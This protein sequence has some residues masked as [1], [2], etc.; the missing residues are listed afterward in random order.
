MPDHIL[1][2]SENIKATGVDIEC[3]CLYCNKKTKHKVGYIGSLCLEC[4]LIMSDFDSW[5][6]VYCFL[7]KKYNLQ[8][9]DVAKLLKLTPKTVSQYQSI[10]MWRLVS[11]LLKLHY[12]NQINR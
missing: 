9:K 12:K 5:G 1:I 4:G 7:K 10:W 3:K 2:P 11:G 6:D 8:R